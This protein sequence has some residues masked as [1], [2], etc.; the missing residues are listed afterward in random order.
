MPKIHKWS[1]TYFGLSKWVIALQRAHIILPRHHHKIHHISPHACYYC[2]TTGWLNYPLEVID[3]WRRAE[4]TV[5][6]LTGMQ[7][8]EDDMKWATKLK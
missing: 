8:R 2:I 5:T 7:P 1:H 6:Y 4:K 3:F